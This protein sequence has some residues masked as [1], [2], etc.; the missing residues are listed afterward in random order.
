VLTV[1]VNHRKQDEDI[2]EHVGG[3]VRIGHPRDT[4]DE[5]PPPANR[6]KVH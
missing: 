2:A 3:G 4:S 1:Q 5:R 6:K